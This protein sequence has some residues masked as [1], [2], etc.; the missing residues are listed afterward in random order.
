M[1]Q[2][3]RKLYYGAGMWAAAL[4][5]FNSICRCVTICV[6]IVVVSHVSRHI[7]YTVQAGF[8]DSC[9]LYTLCRTYIVEMGLGSAWRYM[10][11]PINLLRDWSSYLIQCFAQSVC[12][13]LQHFFALYVRAKHPTIYTFSMKSCVVYICY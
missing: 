4:Q 10:A 12:V 13:S 3:M 6:W 7:W 5:K 8:F 11:F 9:A 1:T 2:L